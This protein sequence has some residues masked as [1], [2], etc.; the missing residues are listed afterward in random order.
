M[1][2][3]VQPDPG[4]ALAILAE[5]AAALAD[6][7]DVDAILGRL[8]T[9]AM[10]AVGAPVGVLYLQDQDRSDLQVALTIGL[11]DA[12]RAA[13]AAAASAMDDAPAKVARARI[14][15]ATAAGNFVAAAGVSSADLRPLV[16]RRGGVELPLGVLAVAWDEPHAASSDE[17][18]TLD[19]LASACAVAVDHGRLA[20]M[21]AERSE[22]FERIAHSDPLTGLANQRTFARVLELE[23]ARAGRQGGEVSVAIFDIDGFAATNAAAGHET[24]DD[25][26]R[27][28][29]SVLAES[30][31]LVDTIARYGGD[32]FV[33]VAPGSAGVTVARRVLEGIARLGQV[34]GHPVTV[35]A[36]V[37]R[38][39]SDGATSEELLGA[40]SAA[41]TRARAEG[42]GGLA[43]ATASPA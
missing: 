22:W 20:S 28:V 9:A 37:A 14:A 21:I 25:I 19:A 30:V 5:V 39:P 33:V 1:T 8:L 24:G 6:G 26:L 4:N 10:A 11:D 13:V 16:V 34:G 23:L 40:A 35:S 36:G 12:R 32:E 42:R 27:S 41:L 7:D 2:S 17:T 15:T 31:R 43:S 3:Q 18:R 29:A 38:F